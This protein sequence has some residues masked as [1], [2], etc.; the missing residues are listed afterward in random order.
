MSCPLHLEKKMDAPR[1][2]A[3]P[4]VPEIQQLI[5]KCIGEIRESIEPIMAKYDLNIFVNA[6]T[7][8]L[9]SV[10]THSCSNQQQVDQSMLVLCKCLTENAKT[11]SE[12]K[13][14]GKE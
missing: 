9:M 6:F 10:A 1:A 11:W 4:D 2:V 14:G 13:N 3:M 12:H 5:G 8:V 7:L